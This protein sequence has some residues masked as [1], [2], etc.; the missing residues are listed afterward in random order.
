MS[1]RSKAIRRARYYFERLGPHTQLRLPEFYDAEYGHR[2]DEWCGT[3]NNMGVLACHCGGDQCI[4]MNF[5]DIPCP[6]CGH[7]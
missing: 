3:C 4:C 7:F 6:N 5:G 1:K 2:E